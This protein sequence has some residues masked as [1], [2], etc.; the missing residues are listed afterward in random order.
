MK[1]S[2][3]DYAIIE[4]L[5]SGQ[6]HLKAHEIYEHLHERFPALNPS[7]VY[8]SMERLVQAGKISVSDI[9][10]GASVYEL[11]TQGIHHHLICQQC[12]QVS[13]IEHEMVDEF[14]EA[15]E[16]KFQFFVATNH[17]VLFGICASCQAAG[18]QE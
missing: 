13:T 17:L 14:F 2:S 7:T 16:T 1:T 11:V 15:I 8:R 9:G 4:L 5:G 10:T 18:E 3:V 12:G 6:K